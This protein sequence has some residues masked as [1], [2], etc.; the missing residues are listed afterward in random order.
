MSDFDLQAATYYLAYENGIIL[1]IRTE[2]EYDQGHLC[3]AIHVPTPNP[4]L[5]D[6]DKSVLAGRLHKALH[7]LSEQVPLII[8]CKKGIRAQ[9][10]KDILKE[11]GFQKVMNLGGVETSPLKEIMAG[12]YHNPFF[13]VCHCISK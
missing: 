1:D 10:A 11:H 3:Q 13:K 7:G 8:Y 2:T 12:K 6:W 4:P 5:T 9:V